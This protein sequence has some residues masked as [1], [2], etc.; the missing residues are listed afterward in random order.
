M[1]LWHVIPATLP[2]AHVEGNS[3]AH[4]KATLTGS[5]VMIPVEE[6]RL[7]LGVWQGIFFC[8]YDGPRERRIYIKFIS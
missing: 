5:S 4:L 7:Q 2:Y 8:E 6:G 1:G 3:D